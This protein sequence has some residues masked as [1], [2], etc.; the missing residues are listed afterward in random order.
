M[1]GKIS[2]T[3]T[4]KQLIQIKCNAPIQILSKL[5]LMNKKIAAHIKLTLH[6]MRIIITNNLDIKEI[7]I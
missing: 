3:M 1:M 2:D 7:W 5:I 4:F 6:K